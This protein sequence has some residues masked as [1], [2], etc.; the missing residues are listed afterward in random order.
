[1]YPL[2]NCSHDCC[3]RLINKILHEL[4]SLLLAQIQS[5]LVL[6]LPHGLVR[7][8]CNV[9]HTR[10]HHQPEQIEDEASVPSQVQKG[11]VALFPELLVVL[12]LHAPKPINHL[13]TQLH[14][15]GE[16]LWVSAK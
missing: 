6:H 11:S 3:G 14:W 12:A 4:H 10:V 13:L 1:M 7:L 16:W 8:E 15:R 2:Y 5:E 9:R